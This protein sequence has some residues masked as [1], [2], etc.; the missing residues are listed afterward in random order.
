MTGT[1]FRPMRWEASYIRRPFE[2]GREFLHRLRFR[3]QFSLF[4]SRPT[5]YVLFIF[6][7]FFLFCG[8]LL[9]LVTFNY[10]TPTDLIPSTFF[11]LFKQH[12]PF[13]L[14]NTNQYLNNVIFFYIT[15]F[16]LAAVLFLVNLRYTSLTTY[17]ASLWHYDAPLCLFLLYTTSTLTYLV[18]IPLAGLY[19]TL[20]GEHE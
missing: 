8:E 20:R 16:S 7:L 11:L 14:D 15:F 2:Q 18:A 17:F 9:L 12:I 3:F 4:T 19:L 13:L 10:Q 5:I 1:M 6:W